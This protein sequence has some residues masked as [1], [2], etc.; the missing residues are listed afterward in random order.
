MPTLYYCFHCEKRVTREHFGASYQRKHKIEEEDHKKLEDRGLVEPN[1]T[2]YIC[3]TGHHRVNENKK[4]DE[5][6][7]FPAKAQTSMDNKKKQLEKDLTYLIIQW[8][9]SNHYEH[10]SRSVEAQSKLFISISHVQKL[11]MDGNYEAVFEYINPFIDDIHE[12]TTVDKILRQLTKHQLLEA[13]ETNDLIRARKI[14]NNGIIALWKTTSPTK[15][16]QLLQY[17]AIEDISESNEL[18]EFY[19]LFPNN[20][21]KTAKARKVCA[22]KVCNYLTELFPE[23][24]QFPSIPE[25]RLGKLINHALSYQHS[26]CKLKSPSLEFRSLFEDHKCESFLGI[27]TPNNNNNNSNSNNNNNNSPTS[28]TIHNEKQPH[29]KIEEGDENGPS[30]KKQKQSEPKENE[31]RETPQTT[32]SQTANT[33]DISNN[34]N[35]NNSNKT[36]ITPSPKITQTTPTLQNSNPSSLPTKLTLQE[37]TPPKT[38]TKDTNNEISTTL[39][40]QISP[41]PIKLS[42]NLTLSKTTQTIRSSNSKFQV[43]VHAGPQQ[44]AAIKHVFFNNVNKDII[45]IMSEKGMAYCVKELHSDVEPKY[46][47][48]IFTSGNDENSPNCMA[49]CGSSKFLVVGGKDVTAYKVYPEKKCTLAIPEIKSPVTTIAYH[50]EDFNIIGLGMQ[51]G[52]IIVYH[53]KNKEIILQQKEHKGPV[54]SLF[55]HKGFIVSLGAD[56]KVYLWKDSTGKHVARSVRLESPFAPLLLSVC[57]TVV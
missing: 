9:R 45:F 13:L 19:S 50:S 57:D 49:V 33:K 46:E 47:S 16:N 2:I 51:N 23:K 10:A 8:L 17:L 52:E 20:T 26:L 32:S 22:E 55:L 35:N 44:N 34:N 24:M 7:Q 11:I 40:P 54:I 36:D 14:M 29:T 28:H 21:I 30:P 3:E 31:A 5:M 42:S 43:S 37:S 15:Y 4:Q 6:Q 48:L 12:N 39:S 1:E 38:T 56:R 18:K 53:F 41:T 27:T 25:N